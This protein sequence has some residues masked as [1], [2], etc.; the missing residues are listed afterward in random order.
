[1]PAA[2]VE[3]QREWTRDQLLRAL[4]NP[5]REFLSERLGLRLPDSS[6]R[7]PE[8]EPFALD[9]G[10]DRWQRQSRLLDL[11]LAQPQLDEDALARRLLAE[12]RIAPG[13][14]GRAALAHSLEALEPALAA[15]RGDARE[16][17]SLPYELELGEFRL[18]GVLPRVRPDGLRQF[19]ASKAHGKTLLA[20]GLDALVWSAMG[21]TDPIDRIV[22]E[23][24]R[25]QL[26]PLPQ[27]VA[28]E[29]LEKLLALAVRARVEVLP[30][31]PKAGLE[32]VRAD[33][34]AKGLRDAEKSW[35][36]DF[37]E[38]RDAW[39]ST[40][41]RGEAPFVDAEATRRFARL[42]R[43]VFDRLPGWNIDADEE[44][45]DE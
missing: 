24:P 32:L 6:E 28:R 37:G 29:K 42:A 8:S 22:C 4:A 26:A 31:M 20:L 36:G 44:A 14:A 7:L 40:A 16:T 1:V 2:G 27:S 41:L 12:G 33:D 35:R 17:V 9:D 43:E 13:A 11:A 5:S 19:T 30:F 25:A 39:V 10:L 23:Q 38:G 15:W 45:E 21:R 18:S 34:E 3:P